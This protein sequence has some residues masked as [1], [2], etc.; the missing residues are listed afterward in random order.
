[1]FVTIKRFTLSLVFVLPMLILLDCHAS[2]AKPRDIST[3]ELQE[4]MAS[5]QDFALV[6]VL[7]KIIYDSMHLPGSV[8]YPI[9]KLGKLSVLP[10][11]KNIPLVFYCMGYL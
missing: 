7:P 3:I 1:M 8:N 2:Y 11:P 6:N 10:F 4:L 9:G 5:G